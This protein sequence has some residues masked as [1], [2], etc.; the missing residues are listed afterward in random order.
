MN[1]EFPA[2]VLSHEGQSWLQTCH[3]E[4]F[5]QLAVF[6]PGREALLRDPAVGEALQ[7]VVDK[8]L[9]EQSR[10]FASAALM[11]LSDKELQLIAEGQLH[12]MFSYQW[13]HQSTIMRANESLQRRGYETWFDLTNMK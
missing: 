3:A 11:N 12:V 9:C 5:A 7:V 13:D 4:C 2:R 6:P 8:G 1:A 10:D